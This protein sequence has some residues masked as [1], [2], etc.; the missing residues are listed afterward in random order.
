MKFKDAL[1]SLF[2]NKEEEKESQEFKILILQLNKQLELMDKEVGL[3]TK[4]YLQMFN[5]LGRLE[6]FSQTK[7]IRYKI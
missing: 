2:R 3:L 4:G 7:V 1:R 5:D 6:P